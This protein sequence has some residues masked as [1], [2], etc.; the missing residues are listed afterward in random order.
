MLIYTSVYKNEQ[1]IGRVIWRTV[2][3]LKRVDWCIRLERCAGLRLLH[4]PMKMIQ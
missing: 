3:T 4:E 1:C 2:T